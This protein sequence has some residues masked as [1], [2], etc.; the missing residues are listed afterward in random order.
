MK[1][2]AQPYQPGYRGWVKVR[3][4]TSTE[5]TVASVT[6]AVQAPSTLLLGRW[7]S[8][9]RLHYVARTTPLAQAARQEIGALLRAAGP[10]HPWAR[11]RFTVGWG[12]RELLE[13][14]PVDPLL[15]IE[16]AADTSVDEGRYRHPVRYLRVRDDLGLDELPRFGG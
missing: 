13:H 10:E 1:G 15:V 8:A 2:L 11:R 3:T 7:D 6:G 14:Q 5:A 4:R 16:F 9:G 12:S